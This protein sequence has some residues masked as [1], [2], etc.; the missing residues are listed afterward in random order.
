MN[1]TIYQFEVTA[2]RA[3]AGSNAI[4]EAVNTDTRQPSLLCE[5]EAA[6]I[7]VDRKRHF[8][9]VA[10]SVENLEYFSDGSRLYIAS[11]DPGVLRST[12]TELVKEGLFTGA[13]PG[14]I[15]APEAVAESGPPPTDGE[16]VRPELAP[17][18]PSTGRI[19]AVAAA[20]VL[21]VLFFALWQSSRIEVQKL[22]GARAELQSQLDAE[23]KQSEEYRLAA[24]A[25]E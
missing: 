13:W 24:E 19:L 4:L 5:W 2:E 18:P 3:R 9:D 1:R 10:A 15:A 23:K 12:V 14:M 8:Q 17:A 20:V 22:E 25:G 7:G 16:P 6:E 21:I 11:P